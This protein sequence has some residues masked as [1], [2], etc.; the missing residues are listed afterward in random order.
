M[1]PRPKKTRNCNCPHRPPGALIFKPAGIPTK[2]LEKIALDI[3]EL[4][5]L[6]L[7]DSEGFSQADAGKQMGVSRG[8]VQRLV[9]SGRKKVVDAI[10]YSRALVIQADDERS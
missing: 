5:A 9:A 4:E 7:C 6:R 3:D 10:L 8:T 2:E 1:S